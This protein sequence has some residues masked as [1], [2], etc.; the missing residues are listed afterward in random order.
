MREVRK[1]FSKQ[2]A[3][4]KVDFVMEAARSLLESGELRW[5]AY[6]LIHDHPQAFASLDRETLEN[7]AVGMDSWHAVDSFARTLSGPAWREGLID[8]ATIREWALSDD[9]WWR[10]A[11]LVSTVSWNIR[12]HGGTGDVSRTL[13]ICEMLVGDR[14]DAVVKALSWALRQLVEHDP[15]SVENFLEVHAG[16]LAAR[17]KREVR[18]KLDTGLKNPWRRRRR[19]PPL[20]EQ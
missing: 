16:E 17:V 13:S 3:S 9:H 6:E 20:S 14:E 2:L 7:L 8:D 18:N 15:E 11:A 19:V 12:S 4:Q 10:R 5:I 1:R